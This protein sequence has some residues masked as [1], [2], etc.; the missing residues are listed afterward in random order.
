MK[1]KWIYQPQGLL[2]LIVVMAGFSGCRNNEESAFSDRAGSTTAVAES[3]SGSMSSSGHEF[4]SEGSLTTDINSSHR[5]RGR[6]VSLYGENCD[7]S[8]KE[9]RSKRYGALSIDSLGEIARYRS[10]EEMV[11]D[12]IDRNRDP[13]AFRFIGIVDFI[14]ADRLMTPEEMQF[15]YSKLLPSPGGSWVSAINPDA[16]EKLIRNIGDAY[17]GTLYSWDEIQEVL[18]QEKKSS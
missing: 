2:I 16:E 3:S 6:E 13:E 9:I 8:G 7:Y 5:F 18:L 14:S 17:P 12:M 10:V 1:K 15:Y 4:I 11:W